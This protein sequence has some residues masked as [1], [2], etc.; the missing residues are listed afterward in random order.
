MAGERLTH[1]L[2][3]Q[4]FTRGFLEEE[5]FPLAHKM[6]EVARSGGKNSLRGK[7]VYNLFYEP[8]T[9]TRVSFETATLLLGGTPLSTENAA[10]FSSAIKGESLEDTIRVINGYHHDAIV[11][12]HKE[13]GTAKRAAEVSQVPIINAGDGTGQ[14]PTQALLDVY[15]IHERLGQIDGVRVAMVGDLAHGRTIN[16]L[17][18]LLAKFDRV[19]IDFIA[20][21]VFCAQ[22]GIKDY[23][24]RH[25][26]PFTEDKNLDD[27]LPDVDV[28]YMTR[29]Q[30][31][32]LEIGLRHGP[33]GEGGYSMDQAAL[34]RL[35]RH[36]I[37]MHPLPRNNEI[38]VEI[39]SDPRAL[40]FRQAQ[41]GLYIRMALLEML[42]N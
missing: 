14:H 15:T 26:V 7:I 33:Y 22:Q 32:R 38:P 16:S 28:V 4:Q 20:P 21:A 13:E 42:L 19:R 39:D 8:S 35:K 5:L 40:Y 25:G 3:A 17:A 30:T 12:R 2:E 36:A 10:E 24:E 23:L 37:I 6:E 18:Y 29:A 34:S 31:E 9:R 11:L 1:I 27:I 41:N